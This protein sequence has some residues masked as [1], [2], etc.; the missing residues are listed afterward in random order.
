MFKCSTIIITFVIDFQKKTL[1][2]LARI[3]QLIEGGSATCDNLKTPA[4]K[5][6]LQ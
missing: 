6:F 4:I 2:W 1:A 3:T 5:P